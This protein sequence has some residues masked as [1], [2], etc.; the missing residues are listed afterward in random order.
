M[1]ETLMGQVSARLAVKPEL[2]I[3]KSW[4]LSTIAILLY[5]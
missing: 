3:L 4:S 5:V 1:R 2:E